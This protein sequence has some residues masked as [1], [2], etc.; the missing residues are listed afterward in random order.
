MQ[1]TENKLL[2]E[3]LAKGPDPRDTNNKNS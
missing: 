2:I 3:I 1:E